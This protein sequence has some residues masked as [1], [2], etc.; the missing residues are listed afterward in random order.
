MKLFLLPAGLL[1]TF[2]QKQD[3]QPAAKK[4]ELEE[5]IIEAHK[6][7]LEIED[8]KARCTKAAYDFTESPHGLS[9][10]PVCQEEIRRLSAKAINPLLD[11]RSSL[12]R[13]LSIIMDDILKLIIREEQSTGRKELDLL[14]CAMGQHIPGT[15]LEKARMLFEENRR[16]SKAP[17]RADLCLEEVFQH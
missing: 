1:R 2:F 15:L 13:R 4:S 14:I 10:A 17:A 7:L 16:Q 5:K 11:R 8:V 3:S 12:E 6:L 9:A